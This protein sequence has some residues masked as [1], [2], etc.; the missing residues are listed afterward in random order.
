MARSSKGLGLIPPHYNTR[1]AISPG[2]DDVSNGFDAISEFLTHFWFFQL[3][4]GQIL[5]RNSDESQILSVM[6]LLTTVETFMWRFLV[7]YRCKRSC[8][9]RHPSEPKAPRTEQQNSVTW[10]SII[11]RKQKFSKRI[12]RHAN[13]LVKLYHCW[14]IWKLM[15]SRDHSR[16][17]LLWG[18][19]ASVD[20]LCKEHLWSY[21]RVASGW[22]WCVCVVLTTKLSWW[23]VGSLTDCR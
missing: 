14:C 13:C 3:F 7:L 4:M 21:F 1:S 20:W 12:S 22:N 16:L 6:L 2:P 15:C 10:N 11:W 19:P 5:M 17:G 18:L 9:K 23:L 8:L